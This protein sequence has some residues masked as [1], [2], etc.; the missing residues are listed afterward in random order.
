M[1]VVG[2]TEAEGGKEEFVLVLVLKLPAGH[3]GRRRGLRDAAWLWGA[4]LS[5][6]CR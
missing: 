6:V 3:V 1:K 2:S 4:G 5:S